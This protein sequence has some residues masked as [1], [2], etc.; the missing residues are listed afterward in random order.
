LPPNINRIPIDRIPLPSRLESPQQ[1]KVAR[2]MAAAACGSISTD[3]GHR[4]PSRWNGCLRK[5]TVHP[6]PPLVSANSTPS[7]ASR[8]SQ[9]PPELKWLLNQCVAL[10]GRANRQRLAV[11]RQQEA[12]TEAEQALAVA[13]DRLAELQA[14]VEATLATARA[15]ATT[16][17]LGYPSGTTLLGSTGVTTRSPSSATTCDTPARETCSSGW[18]AW[19]QAWR[20]KQTKR[21][22]RREPLR[23]S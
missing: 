12:V 4:T 19:W 3:R 11:E 8:R 20:S 18:L 15:L 6:W 1:D 5:G 9:T 7:S 16:I 2:E 13:R 10:L 21:A 17:E 22:V 23:A 14:S